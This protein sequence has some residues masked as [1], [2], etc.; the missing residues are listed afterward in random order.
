MIKDKKPKRRSS[1]LTNQIFGNLRVLNRVENING[2]PVWACL[3]LCG[4]IVDVKSKNLLTDKSKHCGCLLNYAEFSEEE[5]LWIKSQI[6]KKD[7]QEVA[8]ELGVSR[9]Q[10]RYHLKKNNIK[11]RD[12]KVWKEEEDQWLRDNAKKITYAEAGRHFGLDREV[13]RHRARALKITWTEKVEKVDRQSL[14]V[15]KEWKLLPDNRVEAK[16]VNSI[17]FFTGRVCENG[18]LDLRLTSSNGCMECVRQRSKGYYYDN[19]ERNKAEARERAKKRFE[20]GAY[21]KYL[22]TGGREKRNKRT[23]EREKNDLNFYLSRRLRARSKNAIKFATGETALI[24]TDILHGCNIEFIRSHIE[25]LFEEGMSWENHGLLLD[26][27]QIDEIR[28]ISSFD[29]TDIRQ[30]MVCFNWRNRQPLWSSE[31]RSKY[32]NF[33][34]LDEESWI[35]R[36]RDLGFEGELF[37]I[38]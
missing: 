7:H 22:E 37:T 31:N 26:G 10:L 16:K 24:K 8:D 33:S 1:D 13:V 38:Y 27:W 32:S 20:S 15:P 36:M 19:H 14:D 3:C 12:F 23:K 6:G 30:Q 34:K 2:R 17:H 18:H 4:N 11:W 28:P 9:D 5:T 25:S 29:L 21:Q 35:K